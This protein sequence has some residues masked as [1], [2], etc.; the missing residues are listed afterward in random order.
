MRYY[1]KNFK[2]VI[3]FKHYSNPTR[4]K[5]IDREHEIHRGYINFPRLVTIRGRIQTGAFYILSQS[6]KILHLPPPP[7]KCG[8]WV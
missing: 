2:W 8:P 6:S 4:D 7:N 5:I 1:G 3:L